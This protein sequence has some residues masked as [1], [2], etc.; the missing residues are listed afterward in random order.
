[1]LSKRNIWGYSSF[2]FT[3]H[4][5]ANRSVVDSLGRRT[6]QTVNVEGNFRYYNSIGISKT[7]KFLALDLGVRL[8]VDGSRNTSFV[9]GLKNITNQYSIGPQFSIGKYVE[10]KFSLDLNF[11][12]QYSHS[13]SSINKD[14]ATSYWTYNADNYFDYRFKKGWS[15][16]TNLSYNFRQKFSAS[17]KDFVQ[18]IW[19]ASIEK[20]LSK[21]KDI[22]GILTVNDILNQRQ[23][24]SRDLT[25]N[26][27]TERRNT[28]VQRYIMLSLRW[29]FS[30]NRKSSEDDE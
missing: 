20:K 13:V 14:Q 29:K 15:L 7:I 17:D 30:K 16:N 28:T 8:R 27:I 4:A 18:T 19:N 22:T 24:F 5:F 25:S 3:E 21:K 11:G 10:K 2:N 26:Y 12:G 1:V 9:N 23:G 6:T